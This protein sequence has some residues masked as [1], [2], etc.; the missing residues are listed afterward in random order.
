VFD[1]GSKAIFGYVEIE[2]RAANEDAGR[3]N[4]LVETVFAIDEENFEIL[5]REQASTL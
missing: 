4:F 5:S 3:M 2:E 1:R